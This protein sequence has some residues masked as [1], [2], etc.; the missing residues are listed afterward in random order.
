MH[1]IYKVDVLAITN[2]WKDVRGDGHPERQLFV[3]REFQTQKEVS[4]CG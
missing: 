3:Q 2:N 1:V 4:R